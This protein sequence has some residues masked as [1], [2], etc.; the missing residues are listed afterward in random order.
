[1]DARRTA[2]LR[3]VGF[4]DGHGARWLAEFTEAAASLGIEGLEVDLSGVEGFDADG[5]RAIGR[6]R[7]AAARRGAPLV[8]RGG[9][10]PGHELL[11]AA[12]A[13]A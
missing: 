8:F 11:A 3:P 7:R 12:A 5:A 6:C 9:N 2:R 1:M 13:G 10:A 4:L